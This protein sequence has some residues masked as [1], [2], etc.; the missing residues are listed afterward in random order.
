MKILYVSALASRATVD[1]IHKAH[2]EFSGGCAA[3]KF[4]R[5]VVEGLAKNDVSVI[6]LSTFFLPHAGFFWHHKKTE[7]NGVKYKYIA[8]PNWGPLRYLWILLSCFFEVVRFWGM[9]AKGKVV[10][11]DVLNVSAC[12]GILAA[13]K[14]VRIKNVG[15][16]TDIPGLRPGSDLKDLKNAAFNERINMHMLSGFSHYVFLTEQMNE[17]INRKNKPYMVMEGLVDFRMKE[18]PA[19]RKSD[20]KVVLYGGALR[21]GYGL[22]LLVEGFLKANV[23]DSELWLF[24]Q[25]AFVEQ[26]KQYVK[27]DNRILFFGS[28]PNEEIVKAETE[29]TLLVNPRPTHEDYTRYSFPSKNMEYMVSGTPLLTT[30]LPGMPKEYHPY[31][32]LFEHGEDIDGFACSLKQVLELTKEELDNKGKKAKVWVL[33]NKNNIMQAGRLVDF[34]TKL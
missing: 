18:Y 34:V 11:C 21:E 33:Q 15:I 19:V 27:K 14:I 26:I 6:S 7:E 20:K 4:N 23:P 3:Q 22:K 29:A 2:P 30:M 5:L 17:V 32:Y 9:S 25:G 31:V 1:E 8:S 13:S 10:M 12:A 28:V 16:V 24:G